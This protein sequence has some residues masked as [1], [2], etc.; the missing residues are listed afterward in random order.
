MD[1]ET[2][3]VRANG[4]NSTL[5]FL[6]LA[7]HH[8]EE[9]QKTKWWGIRP[10]I[11]PRMN[12]SRDGSDKRDPAAEISHSALV[13][14]RVIRMGRQIRYSDIHW[15]VVLGAGT[16]GEVSSATLDRRTVAV[17]KIFSGTTPVETEEVYN[18]FKREVRIL[19][20]I[21][22]DRVVLFHG[23]VE[24]IGAPYCLVFE[25]LEGN[26]ATLLRAVR[27]D[28][29]AITFRVC[30]GI[31]KDAAQAVGYLHRRTPPILHRDLK[32]ENLLLEGNFRCKLTDFG[33]SR[34]F[35]ADRPS[36]MT[37]CG[38]PSWVAPEVFRGEEYSEK[39]DV[40][41]FGV[42]FVVARLG[43]FWC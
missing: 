17:K 37:V 21:K 10:T 36:K 6:P 13:H 42:R 24:E 9:V 11:I 40:Y 41:S 25:K 31:A 30:L 18:D 22:H 29:V 1:S 16:Y 12:R 32:A 2:H 35:S 20:R 23:F 8:P 39:V 34:T 5:E 15:G 19:Q 3:I 27:K 43:F 7:R 4:K 38:T 14:Q 33:L 26:V 28:Q